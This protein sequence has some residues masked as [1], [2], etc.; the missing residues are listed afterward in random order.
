MTFNEEW[1]RL[2]SEAASQASTHT[3]IDHVADAPGGGNN[4][5]LSPNPDFSSSATKKKAAVTALEQHIQPDTKS[6]GEV[7]D[8][9]TKAAK[10]GFKNWATGGALGQAHTGW[11]ASVKALQARLTTEKAAL[12]GANGLFQSNDGR[13]GLRLSLLAPPGS[14]V[15]DPYSPYI[16]DPP[17]PSNVSKY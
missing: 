9:S 4:F 1:G 15:N 11:Q 12:S 13:T 16:S 6:A 14:G 10:D 17:Y 3:Q 7:V 5:L 8:D 2:R